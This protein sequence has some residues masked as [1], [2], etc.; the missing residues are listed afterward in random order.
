MDKM[1]AIVID[2]AQGMRMIPM[3]ITWQ[4]ELIY[5]LLVINIFLG[6]IHNFRYLNIWY[7]LGKQII[8]LVNDLPLQTFFF[9]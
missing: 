4:T 8:T 1:Y 5:L 7:F 6:R 3:Q 2:Y 9:Y